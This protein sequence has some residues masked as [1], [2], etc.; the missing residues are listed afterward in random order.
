MD[1]WIYGYMDGWMDGCIYNP[2]FEGKK[3]YRSKYTLFGLYTHSYVRL[4]LDDYRLPH[5]RHKPLD[6]WNRVINASQLDVFLVLL[7]IYL[8]QIQMENGYVFVKL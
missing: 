7:F 5:F 8:Q 2:K 6:C 1:I 3:V 4:Y